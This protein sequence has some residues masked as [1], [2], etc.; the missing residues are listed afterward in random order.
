MHHRLPVFDKHREH[1]PVVNV[2]FARLTFPFL[3]QL[4]RISSFRFLFLLKAVAGPSWN[5]PWSV[6]QMLSILHCFQTTLLMFGK[7][8][9]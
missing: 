7:K 3:M 9:L 1:L 2:L 4:L 5:N 8:R 6:L